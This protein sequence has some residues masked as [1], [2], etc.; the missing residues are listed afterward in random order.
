MAFS[1]KFA[2]F[3]ACIRILAMADKTLAQN[4]Q[5]AYLGGQNQARKEVNLDPLIWDDDV[6]SYAQNYTNQRISDCRLIHSH[7]PYGENLFWGSWTGYNAYDAV[8]SWVNAEKPYYNYT[9]NTCQEGKVCGHYTQVVS[10]RSIR[11]GCGRTNCYNGGVI[12]C[13]S[14]DPPGNVVGRRPY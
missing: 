11:I 14:Y 7:G 3:L 2:F 5:G 10:R 13:C 6:A 8:Y 9:S 12:M 1:K 4:E